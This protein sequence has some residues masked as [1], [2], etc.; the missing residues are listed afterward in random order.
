MADALR[1]VLRRL[2]LGR[3]GAAP[4][5]RGI[6]EVRQFLG[7][8]EEE[9][10]PDQGQMLLSLFHFRDT[11]AREVMTPRRDIVALSVTASLDE[12]LAL[13]N[14]EGQSRIPV[15]RDAIDDVIGVLLVK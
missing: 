5:P 15:Y 13:I 8:S 3:D 10:T 2:G 6:D 12:T 4:L 1:A 11:L 9:L 7:Q 14:E